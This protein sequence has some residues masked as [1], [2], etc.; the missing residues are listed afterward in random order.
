[1]TT[2]QYIVTNQDVF[3]DIT[4]FPEEVESLGYYAQKLA[5]FPTPADNFIYMYQVVDL[6]CDEYEYFIVNH[7][8]HRDAN[9][10]WLPQIEYKK[11]MKA[12]NSVE[13]FREFLPIAEEYA[14]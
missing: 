7:K 9:G 4:K 5:T 10:N 1:M 8:C 12:E 6:R 3:L 13:A 14:F 11:P 2:K